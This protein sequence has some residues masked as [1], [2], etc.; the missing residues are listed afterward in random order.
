MY[1]PARQCCELHLCLILKTGTGPV[2]CLSPDSKLLF[3]KDKTFSNENKEI[4][5]YHQVASASCFFKK[6]ILSLK[7]ALKNAN[8]KH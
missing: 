8:L 1:S 2:L 4:D 6:N 5:Q 7:F 3:P